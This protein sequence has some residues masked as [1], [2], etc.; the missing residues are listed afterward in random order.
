[1][2]SLPILRIVGD[3]LLPTRPQMASFQTQCTGVLNAI[4][5]AGG[6][7]ASTFDLPGIMRM[8]NPEVTP[9]LGN[10][11]HPSF[12]LEVRGNTHIMMSDRNSDAIAQRIIGWLDDIVD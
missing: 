6:T 4:A 9:S 11:S 5:A 1:M 2:K 8:P 10:L 3:N 12:S 7:R